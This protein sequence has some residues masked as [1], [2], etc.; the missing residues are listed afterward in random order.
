[1]AL[2]SLAGSTSST[3][4]PRSLA[5][6]TALG[7]HHQVVRDDQR[8]DGLGEA[9]LAL[10]R[11]GTLG[12]RQQPPPAL[13][14]QG[15][16]GSP[17]HGAVGRGRSPRTAGTGRAARTGR[18]GRPPRGG[19]RR[20]T[21]ARTTSMRPNFWTSRSSSSIPCTS[22]TVTD[23]LDG[24]EPLASDV[25]QDLLGTG[26]AQPLGRPSGVAGVLGST[27]HRAPAGPR[28]ARRPR[29]GAVAAGATG[30]PGELAGGQ[31]PGA[32]EHGRRRPRRGRAVGPGH[33]PRLPAAARARRRTRFTGVGR[34]RA[35]RSAGF[36]S[37][38][39]AGSGRRVVGTGPGR[40]ATG[41]SRRASRRASTGTAG[42]SGDGWT[43]RQEPAGGAARRGRRS[44]RWP[45]ARRW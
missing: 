35:A 27:T 5:V 16:S 6:A 30:A 19:P 42:A 45:P 32:A 8:A 20:E 40:R 38:R 26:L 21:S 11:V 22:R 9:D 34:R 29:A 37:A 41:W 23:S 43:A 33:A 24:V 31:S 1:M 2:G 13:G 28:G 14:A 17:A 7:H 3:S 10:V 18:T 44:R 12:G 15:G 36:V 25:D 4:V 39:G